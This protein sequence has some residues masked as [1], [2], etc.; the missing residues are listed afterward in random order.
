MDK[1]R[2]PHLVRPAD[3]QEEAT[4]NHPLNPASAIVF[5]HQGGKTLSE[6]TGLQRTAVHLCRVPAG[7][8]AFAYHFHH[9]EEEWVYVL[10]GR[11]VADIGDESFE[12]GPGD[13]LGYPPETAGHHLRNPFTE[14]LVCLMGGERTSVEVAE[15]PRLGKRLVRAGNEDYFA[16]TASMTR[17]SSGDE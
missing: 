15:F 17:L 13:F 6:L 5:R 3:I 14:D 9:R 7:K 8:E 10:S 2:S 11:G 16:D 12:I 1:P 4:V